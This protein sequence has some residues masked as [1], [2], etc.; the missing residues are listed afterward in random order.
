MANSIFP[1][2]KLKKITTPFYLY[3]TTLLQ[4]TLERIQECIKSA[5]NWH[6][7]YAVKANANPRILKHI[8]NYGLGIDCVSGGEI[9]VGLENGFQPNKIVF[10]GVG[11][12]DWEINIALDKGIHSFNVESVPELEVIN[13]LAKEKGKIANIAL[14]VNPNVDAHTHEKITTGL[15]ENKF[16]IALDDLK[17]TIEYCSQLS[18]VNYVGL[19]FHIGSQITNLDVYKNLCLKIN[20]IQ[21]ELEKA[22]IITRS[23]N[24]GGG[25]CI[26]YEHP[27][28]NPIPQ[29][30][31]YFSIFKHNL[32]LR[33]HQELHFELG[34]S[35]VG[36]CGYLISK[37]LYVKKGHS[38]QFLILD[39]GFTE[40]IRPAMYQAVHSIENISVSEIENQDKYDVV[41]PI[42]ES[43][44]VFGK[45]ILLPLSKRGDLI[46]L[47]SAGAYGEVM[48]ST[49]NC[50][51]LPKSYFIEEL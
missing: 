9:I 38:K 22:N 27:Q 42:C 44:D 21:D 30:E 4:A 34:R 43:S 1:L 46:A 50:R 8:S 35:I 49:Y 14:R 15:N 47:Y 36:Q 24:V 17:S 12:S 16:G 7:H 33:N 48:S 40:L 29:F 32:K 23:I 18:N 31:E 5:N 13:Q 2:E 28:D 19:H 39:A 51:E 37:V 41:G 11:K 25:L 6:V 10:A 3:N 20:D 26:D 45:D